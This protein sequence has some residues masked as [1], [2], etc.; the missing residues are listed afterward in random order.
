MKC[1]KFKIVN[2]VP[3]QDCPHCKG[4]GMEFIGTLYPETT[5]TYG[6]Q[7]CTVCGGSK[8]IPMAVIPEKND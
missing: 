2:C 6:Y 5:M 7:S 4:S 8:V 1:K 3:F